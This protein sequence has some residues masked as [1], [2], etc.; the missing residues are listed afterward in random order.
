MYYQILMHNS[1]WHKNTI[2]L[3]RIIWTVSASMD[4]YVHTKINFFGMNAWK[5]CFVVN[6]FGFCG[7]I[8]W[9]SWKKNNLYD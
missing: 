2:Y 3:K 7:R 6:N 1:P 4:I 5:K 9:H 8:N